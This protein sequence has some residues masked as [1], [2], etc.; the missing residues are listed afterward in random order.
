MY[1][2]HK[3]C[4]F[5]FSLHFPI[6]ILQLRTNITLFLLFTQLANILQ[7]APVE[8][9][10]KTA[11]KSP[12]S[13][14]VSFDHWHCGSDDFD[15]SISHQLAREQCPKRMFEADLC[16]I[17]HDACYMDE[18]RTRAICDEQFCHCLERTVARTN[19]KGNNN[20]TEELKETGCS[21][22]SS[23]F[24]H[25]VNIF[26]GVAYSSSLNLIK[27][28][29]SA[30]E[31]WEKHEKERKLKIEEEKKNKVKNIKKE[32]EKNVANNV[33]KLPLKDCSDKKLEECSAQLQQC[34]NNLQ[35]KNAKNGNIEANG[36][37]F[38]LLLSAQLAECTNQFCK[39]SSLKMLKNSENKEK[40]CVNNLATICAQFSEDF[41]GVLGKNE[42]KK[43]PT[44]LSLWSVNLNYQ[45]GQSVNY[46]LTIIYTLIILLL[47]TIFT[48]ILFKIAKS[49]KLFI[50]QK[51]KQKKY[52]HAKIRRNTLTNALKHV[53][54]IEDDN[55]DDDDLKRCG[56]G[57]GPHYIS[58]NNQ[59][60]PSTVSSPTDCS[61]QLLISCHKK[62]SSEDLKNNEKHLDKNKTLKTTNLLQTSIN[63]T[64]KNIIINNSSSQTHLIEEIN[65]ST[66]NS[67]STLSDI[68][69]A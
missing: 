41:D 3:F 23:T 1:T 22:V 26:G 4:S 43:K 5:T 21:E 2:K 53:G 12:R 67:S 44:Y 47:L 28:Q 29:K 34:T 33:Y 56:K 50:F 15:R 14:I 6:S 68:S 25:I 64:N 17:V 46:G 59:K 18:K 9:G 30:M 61:Q 8:S 49:I 51:S 37:S 35:N 42:E 11:I 55:Y 38:A 10:G 65:N 19:I 69:S 39:C 31:A 45:N 16:C 57:C 27:K 32:S 48:F 54:G 7:S 40:E 24:C 60:K 20:K 52:L 66:G 36:N 63:S 62:V 13:E 58:L